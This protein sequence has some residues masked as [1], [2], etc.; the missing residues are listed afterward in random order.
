MDTIVSKYGR[1]AHL[2]TLDEIGLA[3]P[4]CKTVSFGLYEVY[5]TSVLTLEE[6]HQEL[7]DS[8]RPVCG[9]CFRS[10]KVDSE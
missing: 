9:R 3:K 2:G 10:V 4:S 5:E 7:L 6:L 8:N 1:K